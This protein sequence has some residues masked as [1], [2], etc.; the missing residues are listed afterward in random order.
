MIN[1]A[2]ALEQYRR[3]A[4]VYDSELRLFEPIRRMSIDRLQLV[5]GA[6]VLD[7][8]CGTGLSFQ[9]LE[10]IV[11]PTGCIVGIEQ[12]PEMLKIAQQRVDAAGWKNIVLLNSQADGAAVPR[13]AEAMLFHFTHDILQQPAALAHLFQ[14]LKPKSRVVAAGLNWS[15]PWDWISNTYVLMAALYSTS[16][17]EGLSQPWMHL[18][19]RMGDLEIAQ[20]GAFFIAEGTRA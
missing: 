1:K 16:S 12:C 11:G 2:W 17:M 13:M 7:V 8:G 20:M 18:G 5:V 14:F 19:A 3:R 6:T 9:Q 4:K 10:Q 15:A